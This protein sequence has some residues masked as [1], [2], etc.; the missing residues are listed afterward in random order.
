MEN[1]PK[2]KLTTNDFCTLSLI[3][4][5]SYGKVLLVK[6]NDDNNIFAMK[7]LKKDQMKKK[8]QIEHVKTERR[9]LVN[10]INYYSFKIQEIIDHPFIIKLRYA[11]QNEKKLFL[12]T[13]YCAGG[14]LFY[15]IQKV[16]RFNEE[17]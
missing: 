5:G 13:D 3:G 14:E 12:I 7:I 11:F 6:K 15:H 2:S 1:L 8:N 17:A 16:E 10:N 9:I 4:K